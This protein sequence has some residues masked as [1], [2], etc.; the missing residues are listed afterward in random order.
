MLNELF[1][2]E[3]IAD[4]ISDEN[5]MGQILGGIAVGYKYNDDFEK[6]IFYNKKALKGVRLFEILSAYLIPIFE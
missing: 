1:E 3:R 4:S 6:A 2:A 5:F